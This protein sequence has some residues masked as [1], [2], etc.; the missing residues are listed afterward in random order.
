MSATPLAHQSTQ[1]PLSRRRVLAATAWTAPVIALAVT[2]PFAAASQALWDLS[3]SFSGEQGF[4]TQ[5]SGTRRAVGTGFPTTLVLSSLDESGGAVPQGVQVI[6]TFDAT[7]VQVRVPANSALPAGLTRSA[8]ADEDSGLINGYI[9]TFTAPLPYGETYVVPLTVA[10]GAGSAEL[11]TRG[12]TL[13]ATGLTSQD[14]D[15]A[16]NVA[17]RTGTLVVTAG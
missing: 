13:S 5:V 3:P 1:A 16:N 15:P 4:D 6:F 7:V 10:P 14:S 9:F 8:L 2:S 17:S 12:G 11:G